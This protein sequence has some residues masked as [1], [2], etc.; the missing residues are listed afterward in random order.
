MRT[1]RP[2]TGPPFTRLK[3]LDRALNSVVAGCFLL[4]RDDPT[5]PF[6]PRQRRQI[7]PC[8]PRGRLRAQRHAQVRRGFVDGTGLTRF[9]F[10]HRFILSVGCCTFLRSTNADS[11]FAQNGVKKASYVDSAEEHCMMNFIIN[12]GISPV[13][14]GLPIL[15]VIFL[16][17]RFIVLW[18]WRVNETVA[19]L[20]SIDAKLA[21]M[22]PRE[23]QIG[24]IRLGD[25]DSLT[26]SR[27]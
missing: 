3:F 18:Y 15:V 5:D 9:A 22:L 6:V 21:R 12:S 24:D 2:T 8:R 26:I 27:E 23:N 20:K 19:L 11:T 10:F 7:L 4:G 25:I 17:F 16:I 1:A 13:L 14:I